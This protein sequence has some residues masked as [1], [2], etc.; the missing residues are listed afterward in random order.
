[1]GVV[2]TLIE[3][4]RRFAETQFL[5]GLGMRPSY[6]TIVISCL[7]PR[8]DPAVVLGTE[9]GQIAVIR[10][11]GGRITPHTLTELV[12]LRQLAQANGSDIGPG[13][14]IA[15]LQHTQCGI[16]LIQDRPDLLSRY[17]Q[18]DQQNLPGVSVGDPRAAVAY[19]VAVL[20]AETRLAGVHVSGL[21]YDVTTGLVE[22]VVER[23]SC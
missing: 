1:M 18:I 10:N 7:D 2:D 4:N 23:G 6:D 11:V 12:M 3:G 5:D 14:E 15:V 16:T 8:V 21:V 19:D 22:T 20:R 13:W 9:Q 17:F